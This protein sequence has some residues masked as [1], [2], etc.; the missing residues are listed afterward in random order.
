MN[1]QEQEGTDAAREWKGIYLLGAVTTIIVL[2][3]VILDIIV[4]SVTGGGNL[5]ALPKTAID[6]FAELQKNC[7]LDLYGM[8]LLNVINQLILIPA[9][10]ALYA[11]HRKHQNALAALALIVFLIGTTLFVANNTALTMLDLSNKYIAATSDAQK[12]LIA[13]GGEAMLAKGSHGSMSAFV[14]F[15]L[16][17][18]AGIIMSFVMLTGN[19]FGRV[20]S[21]FGI[22][23]SIMIIM[24]LV[25]VTFTPGMKSVALAISAPGGILLMVWMVLFTIRLFKMSTMKG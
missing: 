8:D 10:F 3:G 21:W 15:L 18:I 14:G 24:Y 7:L 2:L 5:T 19:V 1:A 22:I 12:T 20:N 17:N 16:P 13:A 23:G 11:A 9:Y 6:K 4:G 25:L